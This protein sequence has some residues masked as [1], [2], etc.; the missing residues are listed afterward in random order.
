MNMLLEEEEF[1]AITSVHLLNLSGIEFR[2]LRISS[3]AYVM[4]PYKNF[5]FLGQSVNLNTV[6]QKHRSKWLRSSFIDVTIS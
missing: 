3:M 2:I 6:I 5:S 1:P 4:A